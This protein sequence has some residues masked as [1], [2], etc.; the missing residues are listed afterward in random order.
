MC[1]V[2]AVVRASSV[3]VLVVSFSNGNIFHAVTKHLSSFVTRLIDWI[4][5]FVVLRQVFHSLFFSDQEWQHPRSPHNIFFFI[6]FSFS[7]DEELDQILYTFF[8]IVDL[9]VPNPAIEENIV[10]TPT[11]CAAWINYCSYVLKWT[12]LLPPLIMLDYCLYVVLIM[13]QDYQLN[14]CMHVRLLE[15]WSITALKRVLNQCNW[16]WPGQLLPIP[17]KVHFICQIT[18]IYIENVSKSNKRMES[19]CQII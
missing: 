15:F 7:L 8:W 18:S 13:Q 12:S 11:H 10:I 17:F 14:K 19:K 3:T 4:V 6:F 16:R 2:I 1:F 9:I 5:V